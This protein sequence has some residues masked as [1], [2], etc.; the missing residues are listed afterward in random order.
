MSSLG[1]NF[2][3]FQGFVIQ[4]FQKVK[5]ENQELSARRRN[6]YSRMNLQDQPDQGGTRKKHGHTSKQT[7]QQKQG[8]QESRDD[9]SNSLGPASS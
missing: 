6:Y 8:R 4:E 5:D 3:N 7:D 9:W 2:N 1:Q